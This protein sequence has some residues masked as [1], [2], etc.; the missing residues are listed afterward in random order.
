MEHL[1]VLNDVDVDD[2]LHESSFNGSVL[3]T[4]SNYMYRGQL[5]NFQC[6][7]KRLQLAYS[8]VVFAL[9]RDTHNFST[10]KGMRSILISSENGLDTGMGKFEKTGPRSFGYITRKKL[11]A[12]YKVLRTGLNVLVSDAD[13]HWCGDAVK[14][15]QNLDGEAQNADIII[16]PE[17]DYKT[18]NSGF[19][20]VRAN[21]R[22]KETFELIMDNYEIGNHDQDVINEVL[23][24]SRFGSEKIYS[25]E[26]NGSFYCKTKSGAIVY[27]L[28]ADKW[29]S[30]GQNIDGISVFLHPRSRLIRMCNRN[31]FYVIHNNYVS[32][33]RKEF[34]MIVKGMWF[35]DDSQE[36]NCLAEPAPVTKKA[37]SR[38]STS[39]SDARSSLIEKISYGEEELK[40]IENSSYNNVALITTANY[41]YRTHLRNFQCALSRL[42]LP[43]VPLVLSQDKK[44]H[45]FCNSKGLKSILIT[46]EIG[47]DIEPGNFTKF[48]HRSFSFITRL[49]FKAVRYALE[50]NK[51]ILFSD[52][53]IHWC[54][55]AVEALLN[56]GEPYHLADIVV[57]PEAQ[58]SQLNSG[59][60]FVRSNSR[61]KSLFEEMMK[62][63][64]LGNHDQDVFNA[65]LCGEKFHA[66]KV[67]SQNHDVPF[68]CITRNNVVVRIL[69]STKWPSGNEIVNG[70]PIFKNTRRQLTEMCNSG[71]FNVVHN[72]YIKAKLKEVRMI[73]K[74]MWFYKSNDHMT[75]TKRAV[76]ATDE[77]RRS[78]GKYCK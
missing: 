49:K 19:Y 72:N 31:R 8:P 65:F 74:G 66:R 20:Y 50:S 42:H 70:V 57:M 29:P 64:E 77:S 39:C 53:D 35:V 55:D 63:A 46:P 26:G 37:R 56:L 2:I 34:R 21:K 32:A 1:N 7:L 9:D 68:S 51:D 36:M 58:Y 73:V 62:A 44:T 47:E 43:Y 15:I 59:F 45:E 38:C 13:I 48:G 30:G 61:T 23:C 27:L 78:C 67:E 69:P 40:M 17:M 60:Y 28:D 3:I 6:S 18:L 76:I 14:I 5:R 11:L 52:A 41:M 54:V 33:S 71:A 24:G 22:T 10:T 4:I 25:P 16:M 12:V 75:C